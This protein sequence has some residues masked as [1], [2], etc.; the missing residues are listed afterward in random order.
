MNRQASIRVLFVEPNPIVGRSVKL[1]VQGFAGTAMEMHTASSLNELEARARENW[2]VVLVDDGGK[3]NGKAELVE[4]S[5][6]LF[7][8]VPRISVGASMDSL[9]TTCAE[10]SID[11]FFPRIPVNPAA[12]L[13]S[14]NNLIERRRLEEGMEEQE[15]RIAQSSN[16]DGISG[17][18][19]QAYTLARLEDA[20]NASKR[21]RLDLTL[22]LMEIYEFELLNQKYG[23]EVTHEVLAMIGGILKQSLRSTDFVGRI[24]GARFCIVCTHTPLAGMMSVLDRFKAQ[25]EN[26]LFTGKFNENFTIDAC[27]G[28]VPLSE[29]Y[30]GFDDFM[31]AAEKS[32]LKA[33]KTA[34]GHV[35]VPDPLDG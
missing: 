28:V 26:R 19:G 3:S 5:Q 29:D 9:M 8:Q 14:V 25:I 17:T 7:Q 23:F 6:Q 20:F 13:R 11:D 22:C 10:T 27:Y 1:Y 21:Y 18:W 2:D 31:G 34:P 35:E 24:G 4:R 12:L 32:L 30:L 15:A 33:I 16:E